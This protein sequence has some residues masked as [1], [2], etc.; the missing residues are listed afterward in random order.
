MKVRAIL[1]YKQ[2][3]YERINV[4]GK[5]LL[6]IWRRGGIGKVP[7]LEIDGELIC[8][9]TDIAY[10]LE[11]RVPLPAILPSAS[12]ERGLCHA[13]EDWADESLYWV[14]LY[15]QWIDPEGE[16]LVKKA[17]R[18]P[19][20]TAVL[21]FYKKRL[22]RQLVGQGTARKPAEHVARDLDRHLDALEHML[23]QRSFLVADMPMLCDFAVTAQVHYLKRTPVGAR[24]LSARSVI[25]SYYERMR[26]LRRSEA[27]A[28][29]IH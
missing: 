12:R 18:G 28:M 13:V 20:G 17:F 9:S 1:D 23:T 29:A 6:D 15:Y 10:A 11:E 5:P 24:A 3:A 16:P 19:L 2:I 21:P 4:L 27:P 7:A 8:D 25:G 26:A 22:R 14:G